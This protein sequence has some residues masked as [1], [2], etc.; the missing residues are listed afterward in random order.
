MKQDET[1]GTVTIRVP[2]PAFYKGI[3]NGFHD[4]IHK[5]KHGCVYLK[6]IFD[7]AHI[8]IATLRWLLHRMIDS[9]NAF[10]EMLKHSKNAPV[11]DALGL[12]GGEAVL[13]RIYRGKTPPYW[14]SPL[15]KIKSTGR[16]CFEMLDAEVN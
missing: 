14:W 10:Y 5:D 7:M 6:V 1:S 9:V 4:D 3:H 13:L 12:P 2:A 11:P 15:A 16:V 8:K